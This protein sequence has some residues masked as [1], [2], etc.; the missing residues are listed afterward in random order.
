LTYLPW[1]DSIT[2]VKAG[3]KEEIELRLNTDYENVRRVLE[4][5]LDKPAVRLKAINFGQT[6]SSGRLITP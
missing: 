4:E 1:I 3:A 5:R 2:H 6:L